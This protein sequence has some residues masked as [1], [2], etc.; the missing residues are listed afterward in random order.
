[1][2]LAVFALA[3]FSTAAL[4]QNVTP[5]IDFSQTPPISQAGCPVAFTNVS[6]ETRARLMPVQLGQP[7]D[8]SLFFEYK[9]QSGRKIQ[10]IAVHVELRFKKSVY[11][12]DATPIT[13]DMMLTGTNTSE[14]LPLAVRAY[15]LTRVTLQQVTYADGTI[16]TQSQKPNCAYTPQSSAENIGKLQ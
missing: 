1:M 13:L 11:D 14:K 16:W 15:G 10:S 9:N 3:A 12:L 2:K 6:L 5:A 4:A 8:G 7:Q